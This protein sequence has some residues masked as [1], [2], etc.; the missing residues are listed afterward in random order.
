MDGHVSS[1]FTL[2]RAVLRALSPS[3]RRARLLIFTFHRVL[4]EPDSLFPDEP[5]A[6]SFATMLDWIG[7][8]CRVLPLPEA[9]RGLMRGALPD[10]AACITFDDGYANNFEVALPLLEQR[11]MPATIFIAVDAVQ[12]GIMWN[13]L[14]IEAVRRAPEE[15]ERALADQRARADRGGCIPGT[16]ALNGRPATDGRL[17]KGRDDGSGEGDRACGGHAASLSRVLEHF[18]YLPLEERWQRASE[19]FARVAGT[20]P[21]RLMMTPETV[22]KLP[23]HGIDVGAHTVNHPILKGLPAE[24]AR[25]EIAGSRTW[26]AEVTGIP[27]TSFAYPNGRPNRDYDASHAA[28]VRDAGF[29]LAV[30]THWGGA[31]RNASPYELPRIAPWD[32]T[33]NRFSLR[34]IHTLA[35]SYRADAIQ[36]AS[37]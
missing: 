30:T 16:D 6:R 17:G 11:G 26:V 31:S 15:L 35:S 20:A 14:I 28:M 3:G 8:L 4:P 23:R 21:P 22:S 18:K 27:P 32:R 13:D 9:V 1:A 5:D 36:C 19:L 12:R 2:Q 37:S 10:R 34:L 29:E 7:S 33:P 24:R 25:A